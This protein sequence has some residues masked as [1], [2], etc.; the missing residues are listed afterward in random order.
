MCLTINKEATRKFKT[1]KNVN[2]KVTVYKML[3][4]VYS[5]RSFEKELVTPFQRQKIKAGWLEAIGEPEIKPNWHDEDAIHGGAIHVFQKKREVLTPNLLVKCW[6]YRKDLV[7]VGCDGDLAFK[8][9]YIPQ[10]E[11]DA[12]VD[13]LNGV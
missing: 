4:Y 12:A 6:A 3:K 9:I 7:A 5:I 11:L 2:P 1:R 13:I 8:K 10:K